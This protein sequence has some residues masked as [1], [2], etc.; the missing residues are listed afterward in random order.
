[1]SEKTYEIEIKCGNCFHNWKQSFLFG[2]DVKR[3]SAYEDILI[4]NEEWVKCPN[5]GSKKTHKLIA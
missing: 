3:G 4:C 5:C 1:M 2:F